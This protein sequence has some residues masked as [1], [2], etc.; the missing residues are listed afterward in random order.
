MTEIKE[1]AALSCLFKALKK[2][3]EPDERAE[4]KCQP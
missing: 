3:H 4:I 2:R 1:N